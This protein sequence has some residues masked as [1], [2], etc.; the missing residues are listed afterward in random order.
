MIF[1]KFGT[2]QLCVLQRFGVSFEKRATNM[3][4]AKYPCGKTR[5]SSSQHLTMILILTHPLLKQ[6]VH[7]P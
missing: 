2:E 7:L 6:A 5:F 3:L 4:E 1:W